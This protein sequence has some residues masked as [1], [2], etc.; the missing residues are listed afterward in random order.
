MNHYNPKFPGKPQEHYLKNRNRWIGSQITEWSCVPASIEYLS[1]F[2][3]K[4]DYLNPLIQEN[5]PVYSKWGITTKNEKKIVMELMPFD[6]S[7]WDLVFKTFQVKCIEKMKLTETS[8]NIG[9]AMDGL[10]QIS[11]GISYLL[12][13]DEFANIKNHQHACAIENA[14]SGFCRLAI[15]QCPTEEKT[16]NPCY[17]DFSWEKIIS[18][19]SEIFVLVNA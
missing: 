17:E 14:N 9:S 16:N 10:I 18:F 15:P 5:I 13:A 7:S 1:L 19:K 6:N 8:K 11:K 2:K 12:M 3:M 4:K